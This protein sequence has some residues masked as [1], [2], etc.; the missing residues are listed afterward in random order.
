MLLRVLIGGCPGVLKS[1]ELVAR[2]FIGGGYCV[3]GGC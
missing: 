2:V 1:C 3:I